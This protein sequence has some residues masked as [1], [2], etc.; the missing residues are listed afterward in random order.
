MCWRSA[1][2]TLSACSSKSSSTTIPVHPHSRRLVDL[3]SS[4]TSAKG[5]A[6]YYAILHER[7]SMLSFQPR[8][9]IWK[10]WS[11]VH[12]IEHWHRRTMFLHV[13]ACS[14]DLHVPI[15]TWDIE[16]LPKVE[17]A[18]YVKKYTSR[19]PCQHTISQSHSVFKA[20]QVACV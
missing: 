20:G 6:L 1:Q 8:H 18:R 4:T 11:S 19:N 16:R 14:C 15:L 3:F 5:Q 17:F 7:R 13:S 10:G 9:F 12:G 2:G